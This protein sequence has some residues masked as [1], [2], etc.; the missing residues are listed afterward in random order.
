MDLIDFAQDKNLA[1][2]LDQS[3]GFRLDIQALR[4]IAV[5][6]VL[7]F[8]VRLGPFESGYLG[9]DIFFV[10][11]GFLITK[12]VAASIMRGTFTFAEFYV[13]RARRLLPACYTM[14]A[15]CVLACPFFLGRDEAVD[16]GWQVL[17][18]LTYTANFVLLEQTG[19]F[20]NASDLKP[21]LHMWSLSIEEQYYF[22]MPALLVA[23]PRTRWFWGAALFSMASLL[24]C[25]ALRNGSPDATFYILPTRAW[26]MLLG[27]IGALWAAQRPARPVGSV[28]VILSTLRIPAAALIVAICTLPATAH[29]GLPAFGVCVAT[30]LILTSQSVALV[31]GSWVVLV[32]ES[33][34]KSTMQVLARVGNWSYSLYLAHWPVISFMQSA[35]AGRT[36]D[37]PRELRIIALALSLMAG[38]AL[39]VGVE[40]RFRYSS[41]HPNRRLIPAVLVSSLCIAAAIPLTL[42]Y[43][44]YSNRSLSTFRRQNFGLHENCEY[45]TPFVPKPECA[46]I[47]G[48]TLLLWG[49]SYAM[50]LASG[51]KA[52]WPA[53]VLQATRSSCAP[54]L[55]MAFFQTSA[56]SGGPILDKTWAHECIDFNESVFEFASQHPEIQTVVI[57]SPWIN[58]V[59]PSSSVSLLRIAKTID[60]TYEVLAPSVSAILDQLKVTVDRW[61]RVG[62]HVVL[63]APPPSD[64]S[65][66]GACWEHTLRG[67][68]TLG[69][70]P[71]CGIDRASYEKNRRHVLKLLA[72]V[73]SVVGIPVVRFEDTLCGPRLCST[74]MDGEILYRDSGH[75]T[76]SGSI[77]MARKISLGELL[78]EIPP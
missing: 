7:A 26:E 5:L 50:H 3:S 68:V 71:N 41:K 37:L 23:L 59:T 44:E 25:V 8:H 49:D 30:L 60:P 63:V 31:S 1:H 32:W 74:S 76:H 13:S 64:G 52:A 78:K 38:Y 73:P 14:L 27:S 10:I 20:A 58:H 15:A 61:R 33:F 28:V 54:L 36:N 56:R 62:K 46:S 66:I 55:G 2:R 65:D 75:F 67:Q 35:W 34:T 48:P 29:P 45:T 4:G 69:A 47:V 16:L 43:S 17:G 24:A 12:M 19:Y 70:Q 53:G 72:E 6:V 51:L 22:L 42:S 9:V 39:Y 57:S 21:L 18:T 11:S 40:R 77:N